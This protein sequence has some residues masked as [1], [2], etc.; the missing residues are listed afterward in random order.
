M[1]LR[2]MSRCLIGASALVLATS[3][4]S[5]ITRV[6]VRSDGTQATTPPSGTPRISGNGRYSLFTSGADNLV[7]NDTNGREDT[8]RHDN[9]T[10]TT[11]RVGVDANGGQLGAGSD[12]VG[13]SDDGN[14]VAFA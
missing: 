6:S 10:G 9:V 14:V 2:R 5:F 1:M 3:G 12:A 8:F 13:I 4:C 7:A 11:V